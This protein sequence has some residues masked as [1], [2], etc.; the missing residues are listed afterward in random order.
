[1][2][3]EGNNIVRIFLR[4]LFDDISSINLPY[5]WNS[6]DLKTFSR[7]KT[8]WDFQQKAVENAF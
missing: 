6:F 8:L 7:N 4:V 2:N 5:Y 1:M 3:F